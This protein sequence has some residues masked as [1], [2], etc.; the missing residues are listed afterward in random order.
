MI[1]SKKFV[2]L[3]TVLTGF[4]LIINILSDIISDDNVEYISNSYENIQF[5]DVKEYLSKVDFDSVK[6]R[7]IIKSAS[8]N[9]YTLKFFKYLQLRYK[10]MDLNQHIEEVRQY[11]Y[12]LMEKDDADNLMQ[13]YTK[14]IEYENLVAEELNN[15]GELKTTADFLD[16]LKKMK[17]LQV[18]MFGKENAE[19]I[20][21]AMMK[22]QEYPIRRGG[23]VNDPNLYAFEKEKLLKKLNTDMWGGDGEQVENSRKP[24]VA[25][26]ETL[27]IHSKDMSEMNDNQK[28]EKISEIRK[29]IFPP[30]VIQR[31]EAVDNQFAAE[32]ERDSRYHEEY[33]IINNR[34]DLSTDEKNIQIRKLQDKIYGEDAESVRRIENITKESGEFK[35]KYNLY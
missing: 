24:Y 31:L 5:N 12:T 33:N 25:Y 15:T 6:S 29:S 18:E 3:I 23:I 8:V 17:S 19:I 4:I 11:L 30:D 1:A 28:K 22:A 34:T 14:Y 27:S 20:F 16:V 32:K 13:L 26:T 35:K 7:E 10:D 2:I 9:K 21:G